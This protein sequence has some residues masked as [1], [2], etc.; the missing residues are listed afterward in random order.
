M[1]TILESDVIYNILPHVDLETIG[2]LFCVNKI[3]HKL[4]NDKHFWKTKFNNDYKNV[5]S[6]SEDFLYEYKDI[7]L[8]YVQSHKSITHF[9]KICNVLKKRYK[10]VYG[11]YSIR[12]LDHIT[13]SVFNGQGFIGF[14]SDTNSRLKINLEKY[15]K[16]GTSKINACNLSPD[17]LIDCMAKIQYEYGDIFMYDNYDNNFTFTDYVNVEVDSFNGPVSNKIET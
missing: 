3:V 8:R 1:S 11:I 16:N 9:I 2:N 13:P 5:I 14:S 6:K 10:A 15:D 4:C 7:F 12:V 17:M